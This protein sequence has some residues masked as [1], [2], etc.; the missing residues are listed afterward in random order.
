AWHDADFAHYTFRINL[1][2]RTVGA[3]PLRHRPTSDAFFIG[4]GHFVVF[5]VVLECFLGPRL[6]DD[7]QR[8]LVDTAVVVIY[9]RAVHRRAGDM[10]LLPQHIDPAVLIA[11]RK[12]GIDARSEE[13]RVGKE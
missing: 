3:R 10:V 5:A 4:E 6:P 8:L 12:A 11:A 1:A 13:R 9:R 2:R 7:L